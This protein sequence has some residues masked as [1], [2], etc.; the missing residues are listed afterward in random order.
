[1]TKPTAYHQLGRFIVEF[2]SV[3]SLL[4][5]VLALVSK[6]D[7]ESVYI[8]ANELDFSK[9]LKT[10]NVLFARFVGLHA[11]DSEAAKA[12]FH[13]LVV[14]LGKLSERRNELVHSGYHEWIN[15]E[16]QRGLLRKHSK[17][18]GREGVRQL[19]EEELQTEA[20][21]ADL[22]RLEAAAIEL[23]RLRRDAIYW[24]HPD[25]V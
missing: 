13:S 24:L 21:D 19:S 11:I 15:F 16:G 9:R 10:A 1:M 8:L 6:S 2:Q 14:E 3:E 20:F 4:S 25:V 18:R 7:E 5:D 22:S 12:E 23:E 17:L